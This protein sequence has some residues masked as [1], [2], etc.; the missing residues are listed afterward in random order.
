MP[1]ADPHRGYT[2]AQTMRLLHSSFALRD[3]FPKSSHVFIDIPLLQSQEGMR[4]PTTQDGVVRWL[5]TDPQH[6]S[7]LVISS[8]PYIRYQ[9][10]VFLSHMPASFPIETVGPA[11][12]KDIPTSLVLDSITRHLYQ[13]HFL[14]C[15]LRNSSR[16]RS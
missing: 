6:G 2:E 10:A 3:K 16:N 15:R 13:E 4:H 9:H 5:A 12:G 11:A 1:A 14:A 7:C 8:Q